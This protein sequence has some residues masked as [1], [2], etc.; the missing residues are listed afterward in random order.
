MTSMERS[1]VT[2]TT[3]VRLLKE[4]TAHAHGQVE[5]QLALL[6]PEFTAARLRDVVQRLFGFW[7]GNEPAIEQWS[8]AH[9]TAA[10][11]VD[12]PRR[13]RTHLFAQDL[14]TLGTPHRTQLTVPRAPRVFPVVGPAEVFGWLYVTEGST[15][16]GAVIDRHLRRLTHL[17]A[18]SLRCFT[19]YVEGPGPMWCSLRSALQEWG[20]GGPD[21]ADAVIAAAGATFDSLHDWLA[22]IDVA[23]AT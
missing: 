1:R 8:A 10:M 6:D 3:L 13:R 4:R 7:A 18:P 11:A 21:R 12:W 20:S 19:P 23:A 17:N 14:Q 9:R 5:S 16:G 2:L 15:L 22:P